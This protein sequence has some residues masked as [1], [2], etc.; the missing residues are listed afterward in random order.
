M[1]YQITAHC[2]STADLTVKSLKRLTELTMFR[3]I[4]VA[5]HFKCV[6]EMFVKLYC[7]SD[8]T[9]SDIFFLFYDKHAC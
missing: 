9:A 3:I 2:T 4:I 1:Y 7:V 5:Q 8:K 6:V